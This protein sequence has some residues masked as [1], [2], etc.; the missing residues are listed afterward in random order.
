MTSADQQG[1]TPLIS[2]MCV[3][4]WFE[5]PPTQ[6]DVLL[7]D[8]GLVGMQKGGANRLTDS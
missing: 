3:S 8:D 2:M 6:D 5:S 1:V 4:L 7:A